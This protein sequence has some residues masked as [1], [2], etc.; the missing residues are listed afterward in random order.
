MGTEVPTLQ[1]RAFQE[2]AP[3]V[4]Q[5]DKEVQGAWGRTG[6]GRRAEEGGE[7]ESRTAKSLGARLCPVGH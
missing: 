5:G 4:A 1:G 6:G 3:P 2:E 7:N